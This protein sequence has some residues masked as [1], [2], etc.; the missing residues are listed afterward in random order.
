MNK[1]ESE[2]KTS[3]L[4]LSSSNLDPCRAERGGKRMKIGHGEREK[5]KGVSAL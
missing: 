3:S 1:E 2:S 4:S 5:E